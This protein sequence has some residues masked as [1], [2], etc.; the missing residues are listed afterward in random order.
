MESEALISSTLI[1]SVAFAI[2][3]YV[4]STFLLLK[5]NEIFYLKISGGVLRFRLGILFAVQKIKEVFGI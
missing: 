5:S 4:N 1:K 3:S 2:P